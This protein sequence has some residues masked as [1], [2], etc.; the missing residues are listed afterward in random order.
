M[1]A[2][3][4][5][6]DPYPVPLAR[7]AARIVVA[8]YD[9]ELDPPYLALP[10][11]KCVAIQFREGS[12][13]GSAQFRYVFD[14][15]NLAPDFPRRMEQ[16]YPFSAQGFGV[17]PT[18]TRIAVLAMRADNSQV[19]L[20]DGYVQV[21]Q[22]D[23]GERETVSFIALGTPVREWDTPLGGALMRDSN[24]ATVPTTGGVTN[25]RATDLPARFNPKGLPNATPKG[26]DGTETQYDSGATGQKFPV[27]LDVNTVVDAATPMRVWTLGM[28]ARYL[29]FN[30]NPDQ[31]FVRYPSVVGFG[32]DTILSAIVPATEGGTI[33]PSDPDTF[34]AV[35]IPVPADLDIAGECWPDALEKLITPHGFGMEFRLTTDSAGEPSWRLRI[36]RKDQP[37]FVKS[38]MLQPAGEI[39]DPARTNVGGMRL[40]RDVSRVANRWELQSEPVEFE[41]S[42]VLAPG[43][44]VAAGDGVEDETTR[45]KWSKG[46]ATFD[47]IGYRYFVVGED[48]GGYW[49]FTTSAIVET[50]TSLG[51]VL[52]NSALTGA[53]RERTYVKR[54]RPG[55]NTLISRDDDGKPLRAQLWVSRD[56]AGPIPGVWDRTGTWH[57]ITNGEWKLLDDVLGIEL[58]MPEAHDW[59][60]YHKPA[61]ADPTPGAFNSG[62]FNVPKA[63]A[64]PDAANP[65]FSFRLTC[66]IESDHDLQIVAPKRSAVSP[67]KFTITRHDDVRDRYRKQVL[68]RWSHLNA[69][70]DATAVDVA[71][72]HD[73]ARAQA[74]ADGRRRAHELARFAGTVM[75]PRLVTSYQIGDAIDTIQGRDV[76]LRTNVGSDQ[77]EAPVYPVVVGIDW[78]LDGGQSTTL[79]LSDRRAEP[80][81]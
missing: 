79:H 15:P 3:S 7:S 50:P 22:V 56:Y 76:G 10:N 48:G 28:A 42:F 55:K 65:R 26:P 29:L 14:D 21:P 30:G 8:E 36:Y 44:A 39:L 74:H 77:G 11:V 57:R 71:I 58:N 37:L 59:H 80:A 24:K 12:E 41:A 13:P 67:T 40:A 78:S 51:S 33:D 17:V 47:P 68:S 5:D 69:E 27:F 38:L 62:K 53:E 6:V 60:A 19:V 61:V 73:S 66:V 1:A 23:Y 4:F 43:F 35:E 52:G 20:F 46:Q 49:D 72:R 32:I 34:T 31:E 54:P 64:A 2:G 75:I 9:P 16:V 25:D 70:G 18:D 45:A 63:L 81:R